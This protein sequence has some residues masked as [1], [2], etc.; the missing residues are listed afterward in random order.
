MKIWNFL[1][2]NILFY[3]IIILLIFR[4]ICFRLELINIQFRQWIY[5]VVGALVAIGVI[6]G[7]IQILRTESQKLKTLFRFIKVCLTLFVVIFG[8]YTPAMLVFAY[9][10]EHIIT[11]NDKKYVAY[12]RSFLNV[13]VDYYDYINVFLVGNK[14]RINEYYGKRRV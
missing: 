10:P 14:I 4:V 5:Y 13:E 2:R 12:V 3:T 6:A 7:V 8:C 11:R 1:K 9:M